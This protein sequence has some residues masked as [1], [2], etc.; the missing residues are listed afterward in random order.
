M[1]RG[2]VRDAIRALHWRAS[3]L[4][5]RCAGMIRRRS[6]RPGFWDFVVDPESPRAMFNMMLLG[7]KRAVAQPLPQ[8]CT[9]TPD[10][11]C[12]FVA[13]SPNEAQ[14]VPARSD[15]REA[16]RRVCKHV[17]GQGGHM[18]LTGCIFA[19]EKYEWNVNVELVDPARIRLRIFEGAAISR[20]EARGR[21]F[22][23]FPP[24]R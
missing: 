17:R 18:V 15:A 2:D 24:S 20:P 22:D 16:W 1:E 3:S 12:G 19:G 10:N 14:V 21:E 13:A 9:V 7:V 23:L 6:L 8:E 5:R 4:V 11:I